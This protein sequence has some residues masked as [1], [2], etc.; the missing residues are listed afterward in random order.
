[1]IQLNPGFEA[2][3]KLDGLSFY[4]TLHA[5]PKWKLFARYDNLSSNTPAGE[6]T[7]WDLPNDGQLFIAGFEYS[8]AKGIKLAPSYNGWS[9]KDNSESFIS[10]IYLNC[11]INF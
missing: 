1:M 7:D 5:A 11:E 4:G 8:P 3:R 10:S 9:P 2:D 6:M